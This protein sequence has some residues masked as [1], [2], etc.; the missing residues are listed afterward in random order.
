MLSYSCLSDSLT[1]LISIILNDIVHIFKINVNYVG[2]YKK[3]KF[4]FLV[5]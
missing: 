2:R 4:N 3:Y 1:L 5:I